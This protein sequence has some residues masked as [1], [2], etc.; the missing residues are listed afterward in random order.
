MLGHGRLRKAAW[1]MQPLILNPAE[2]GPA[3][4]GTCG[5]KTKHRNAFSG[6][7]KDEPPEAIHQAF[8]ED[9]NSPNANAS[10]RVFRKAE[11]SWTWMKAKKRAFI[12]ALIPDVLSRRAMD[13]WGRGEEAYSRPH[14]GQVA[15]AYWVGRDRAIQ[16]DPVSPVEGGSVQG[17]SETVSRASAARGLATGPLPGDGAIFQFCKISV[18]FGEHVTHRGFAVFLSRRNAFHGRDP[19]QREIAEPAR[20]MGLSAALKPRCHWSE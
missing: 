12:V 4:I 14:M 2:A 3:P 17:C 8:R 9:L 11:I 13:C 7:P 1:F 10:E 20:D 19:R 6:R 16:K 15:Q 18:M 5:S